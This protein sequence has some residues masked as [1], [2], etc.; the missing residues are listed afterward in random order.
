M[1]S[2]ALRIIQQAK[3]LLNS[4]LLELWTLNRPILHTDVITYLQNLCLPVPLRGARAVGRA[5][6]RQFA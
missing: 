3:I 5:S 6:V 2:S 4:R 1:K